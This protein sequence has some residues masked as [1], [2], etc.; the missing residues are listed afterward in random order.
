MPPDDQ[1]PGRPVTHALARGASIGR[2]V[3]LTLVG[4]GGM[5]EVYAAYD[6]E[7]DRKVAV[8]LLRAQPGNGVSQSEGRARI[9]REAQ[10][11]AKLS[12]PN[13]VVVY[14]VGT[15]ADQVFI[16]MEFLEGNTVSY[17][18][19]ARERNW[20]E[21]VRVFLAAG[22]GLLAAHE[23]DLVHR[24]FKP[25]NIMVDKEGQVRVMD[26]GLARQVN[27]KA[28]DAPKTPTPVPTPTAS[29]AVHVE[30]IHDTL[31]AETHDPGD[32]KWTR[33]VPPAAST[34]IQ[35]LPDDGRPLDTMHGVT[36]SAFEAHLTRTGSMMGTPAYMSPEQFLGKQTD[37]RTDQF[38]FCVALYEGL[39]GERPFAGKTLFGLT[40]NVVKGEISD[41][42]PNSKVPA[43]IRKILLRGLKADASQRY[44][45]MKELLAALE[46]DPAIAR[47]KMALVAA[48][49]VLPLIVGVGVRQSMRA[50]RSM[51]E[52]GPAKLAGIWELEGARP[53]ETARKEAIHKAMLATGKPYAEKVYG[54][55][56]RALN[57]YVK[58]WTDMYR[59]TCEAAHVRGD[60]SAEVLDL[61]M[62]CLDDR[63]DSVK[64]LT[65]VFT[66]ATG[67]VVE[68]AL[69][70]VHGLPGL[71]RCADVTVLRMV[72]RPP[73]DGNVRI[74][75]EQLRHRLAQV[76]ALYDAGRWTNAIEIG[77]VV[78]DQADALG[79]TPL[80]AE[81]M[82]VLGTLQFELGQHDLAERTYEKAYWAAEVSRHDEVRASIATNLVWVV[83]Y[84][85]GRSREA[86][87][88]ARYAD[89]AIRRLGGRER[90]QSWLLTN[91]GG[92]YEL[93]GRPTEALHVHQE[94]L[95]LKQKVLP[96]D[97]PD[98]ALSLAN[99]AISFQSLGQNSEALQHN[100]RAME[101]LQKALG[102]EH[103]DFAIQ[104]NNRGEILRALARP[105]EARASFERARGIWERELGVDHLV[106]GYALT[107]IG[108][109]FLDEGEFEAAIAPLERALTLRDQ[110]DSASARRAETRFAL[111]RALWSG[112]RDTNRARAQT[113]AERAK[114]E[115]AEA[116]MIGKVA[117]IQK[118][119]ATNEI[120]STKRLA[121]NFVVK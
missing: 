119:L 97:H 110:K 111:A 32:M 46:R 52:G 34:R 116:N 98:I 35:M 2:Y 37:A 70:A 15:F 47:K 51:C 3:V 108:E 48:A 115:Y 53:T 75:V 93:Q 78:A 25:D 104:L 77:L 14:D 69:S 24:D 13:V 22:R 72:I 10:A 66:E 54:N 40:S 112:A 61:R 73:E 83:G 88:W 41:A 71:D 74:Q 59:Q 96:S 76:K 62:S 23:K 60:Q 17:W 65:Q 56:S 105:S 114:A 68:K 26:F 99:I 85:Q 57:D 94:A 39:Y 80:V 19:H 106:L 86:E 38:S 109:T 95:V 20:K 44:P 81:S 45:S 92:V 4:K 50:Q 9:L 87:T 82:S 5:G 120:P 113:L 33:V 12:H 30:I 117:E 21:V 7:L 102:A 89:A 84:L 79:Y 16:A 101:I 90:L 43:W 18:L 31:P 58:S 55:V 1:P 118:W 11:I 27:E 42:P 6:P 103:P 100:D 63:L 8:K 28:S 67:E 49:L 91:L 121:R 107:G 64:A 36:S 29:G